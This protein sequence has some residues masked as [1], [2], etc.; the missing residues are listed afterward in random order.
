M[1]HACKFK[2]I[3]FGAAEALAGPSSEFKLTIDALTPNEVT[4]TT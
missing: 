4:R 2:T 3:H 1:L